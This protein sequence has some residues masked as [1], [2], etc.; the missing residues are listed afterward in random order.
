[1][2]HTF[3]ALRVLCAALAVVAAS[4]APARAQAQAWPQKQIT[5]VSSSAPGGQSDVM[6]RFLATL[7]K[8]RLGQP[9]VVE[10]K[11]GG[12]ALVAVS[13]AMGRPADGYT[14]LMQGMG[15]AHPVFN[16]NPQAVDLNKAMLPVGNIYSVPLVVYS[17][18][19]LPVKNVRELAALAK[20][21]PG[22]LKF[23]MFAN[24]F[25]LATRVLRARLNGD[26]AYLPVQ[27]RGD[28]PMITAFLAG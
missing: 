9:I 7:M 8:D 15:S 22:G 14:L 2:Q 23:G 11:P 5:V 24:S 26:L 1:M 18:A 19:S 12:F 25:E 6:I 3:R 4:T 21:Q 20:Q 17:R 16:A 10:N 28:P 13:H 27:Y